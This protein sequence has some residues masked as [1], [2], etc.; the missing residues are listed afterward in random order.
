VSH[1]AR[2][3]VADY[4]DAHQFAWLDGNDPLDAP[5]DS[6]FDSYKG[7]GR[8]RV[9]RDGFVEPYQGDLLGIDTDPRV[10]VL[11]LNPGGYLP[12]LQARDGAFSQQI[13]DVG[14][15]SAWIRQHPYDSPTWLDRYGPNR[16]YGQRMAFTRN[17]LQDPAATYNDMLIFEMYPWHSTG[18]T[19]PM[20]PPT[21]IIK[22]FVWKPVAEVSTAHV[23][24]F[25]APWTRLAARLGLN[26]LANL[27]RCGIPYGSK[28]PSRRVTVYAL[29]SG[30]H[31]VAMSHSG[32]AG[33][34]SA[35][36]LEL[37]RA[38]LPAA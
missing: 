21:E 3:W 25:G 33:P 17:W 37:L 36:E 31:L 5:L 35:P 2:R 34:P 7:T 10:V 15:F 12:D 9:T 24:A 8:G 14:S 18:V 22:Q 19:G 27:G 11:G 23:F 1:A 20:D 28:V 13:R 4:W 16:Y 38:A 29:P 6:W 26:T 32:S 30:Q